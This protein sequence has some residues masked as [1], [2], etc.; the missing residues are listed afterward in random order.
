[1]LLWTILMSTANE[2]SPRYACLSLVHIREF[3]AQFQISRRNRES[4]KFETCQHRVLMGNRDQVNGVRLL[5][6]DISL[7]IFLSSHV[8]MDKL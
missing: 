2:S 1:M 3:Q 6:F 5:L 8:R 4:G 7:S